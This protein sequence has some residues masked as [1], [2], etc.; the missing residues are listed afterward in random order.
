LLI[1]IPD[2]GRVPKYG[3]VLSVTTGVIFSLM[4]PV[5][6]VKVVRRGGLVGRCVAPTV[7]SLTALTPTAKN[8]QHYL[9]IDP[10]RCV[11]L[12]FLMY[13]QII[14]TGMTLKEDLDV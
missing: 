8:N 3:G 11:A 9:E 2:F 7:S 12:L 10:K 4:T 5:N 6:R 1:Y 14:S 13:M